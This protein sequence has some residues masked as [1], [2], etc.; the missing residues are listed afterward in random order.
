MKRGESEM[1][2]IPGEKN[3]IS[4]FLQSINASLLFAINVLIYLMNIAEVTFL[5][6][7]SRLV[8]DLMTG[9]IS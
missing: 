4:S 9:E 3:I 5:Y 1:K 2:K 8:N 6:C 7:V